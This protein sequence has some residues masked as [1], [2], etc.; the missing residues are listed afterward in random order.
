[1]CIPAVGIYLVG[2]EEFCARRAVEHLQIVPFG[3]PV[4]PTTAVT[5]RPNATV[6]PKASFYLLVVFRRVHFHGDTQRE[7]SRE[8]PLV[9]ALPD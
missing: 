8:F 5:L 1:M 6:L 2:I 3:V 9:L 7:R 4:G